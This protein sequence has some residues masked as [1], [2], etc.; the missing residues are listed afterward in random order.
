MSAIDA[1][2]AELNLPAI[3]AAAPDTTPDVAAMQNR[4]PLLRHTL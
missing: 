3:L 1:L 4:Y 2:A